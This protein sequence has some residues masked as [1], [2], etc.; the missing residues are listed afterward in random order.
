MSLE[1]QLS[2][3][4]EKATTSPRHFAEDEEENK[5]FPYPTITEVDPAMFVVVK[6]DWKAVPVKKG[7]RDGSK[8]NYQ[9]VFYKYMYKGKAIDPC[10]VFPSTRSF[11]IFTQANDGRNSYSIS[12][13]IE[14]SRE[15]YKELTDALEAVRIGMLTAAWKYKQTRPLHGLAMYKTEDSLV[16][17]IPRL[18]RYPKDSVTKVEQEDRDPGL[19]TKLRCNTSG[20]IT[21]PFY[22]PDENKDG[23]KVLNP[24]TL[25]VRGC[26][27]FHEPLVKFGSLYKGGS[28]FT[29]QVELVSTVISELVATTVNTAQ[30]DSVKKLTKRMTKDQLANLTRQL[31]LTVKAKEEE[32]KSSKEGT[33]KAEQQKKFADE[34]SSSS[35]DEETKSDEPPPVVLPKIKKTKSSRSKTTPV[36]P[37]VKGTAPTMKKLPGTTKGKPSRAKIPEVSPMIPTSDGEESESE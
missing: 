35:S 3:I 26:S 1:Q 31:D 5:E 12:V 17:A 29:V 11:G 7:E 4:S 15:D 13:M 25:Q 8:G 20:K 9:K 19:W 28:N 14:Q 24:T 27:F 6:D 2:R 37:N 16:N 18:W 30:I 34:S 23:Y 21:T 32:E 22:I 10:F 36:I 33:S